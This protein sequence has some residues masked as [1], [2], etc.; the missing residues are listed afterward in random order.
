M[1]P[2]VEG[3]DEVEEEK[4]MAAPGRGA[5]GDVGD[6]KG[7]AECQERTVGVGTQW[8]FGT[9]QCDLCVVWC[10]VCV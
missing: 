4:D 3:E 5:G 6:V 1:A 10:Y 8:G 9:L 2:K 7:P